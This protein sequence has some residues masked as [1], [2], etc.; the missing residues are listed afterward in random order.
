MRIEEMLVD[1]KSTQGATVPPGPRELEI[2][3]TAFNY[4]K[5][6][7]LR[8]R[9]RLVELDTMWT[10][11][12]QQ[13]SARFSLLPPGRYR[14]EVSA[15]NPDGRSSEPV[16]GLH[17]TVEPFLWQTLW[18]QIGMML[19]LVTGGGAAVAGWAR[20]RVRRAQE[21]EHLARAAADAQQHHRRPDD[22]PKQQ[23]HRRGQRALV[24]CS[25]HRHISRGLSPPAAVM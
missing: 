25:R 21:R 7:Q 3:Y 20:L 6:R 10:E 23:F 4:A 14:F 18:F 1:G 9:H 17:F 11:A 8:F 5:P 16:A 22:Q 2:R 24:H 15:A 19:L 13:R 12:G